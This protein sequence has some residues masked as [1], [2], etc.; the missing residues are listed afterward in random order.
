MQEPFPSYIPPGAFVGESR[1]Y[2]P[3]G[4][5]GQLVD[6]SSESK[7]S[8]GQLAQSEYPPIHGWWVGG[9]TIYNQYAI[10]DYQPPPAVQ[11]AM[12]A[13]QYEMMVTQQYAVQQTDTSAEFMAALLLIMF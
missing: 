8:I 1:L 10:P 4:P 12:M 11:F 2:D 5:V 6:I 3:N 7:M 9:D 13:A